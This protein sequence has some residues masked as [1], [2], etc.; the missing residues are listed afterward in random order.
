MKYH[1]LHE[2]GDFPILAVESVAS[3]WTNTI[4]KVVGYAENWAVFL[5]S[6]GWCRIYSKEKRYQQIVEYV[7]KKINQDRVYVNNVKKQLVKNAALFFEFANSIKK[8]DLSKFFFRDLIKLKEREIQLYH[9]TAIFGEPIPFFLKEKLQTELDQYLLVEKKVPLADYEKLITPV[10]Q[11]F[12]EREEIEL[13]KLSG[14]TNKKK[15][16]QALTRHAAKYNWIHFDYASLITTKKDFFNKLKQLKKQRPKLVSSKQRKSDKI[17][18]IKK[19]KINSQ[20]KYWLTVLDQAYFLMDYKKEKLTQVH[21][22]MT[23]VY[24]E[25]AKRVGLTLAEVRWL[26]WRELKSALHKNKKILKKFV[27]KRKRS[28]FVK[29]LNG[30]PSIVSAKQAISI[31]RD[32]N[33]DQRVDLNIKEISGLSGSPGKVRGR[34]CYLKSAK[35]CGKIKQGEILLV[36]NTTPDFMPA[37][38]KAKA[39]VTCEGGITCHAA[40][41]SRE[42]KIPCVVGTKIATQVLK[43][44]DR[45]EVNASKGIVRII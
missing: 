38:R 34:I 18:L 20:V 8:Y 30:H 28:C 41:V 31:I 14:I 2:R 25:M 27:H 12:I 9:K 15:L 29:Y 3:V 37:I 36:S 13:L 44:G 23:A 33:K 6:R 4:C 22:A 21:F 1:F 26:T 45:V 43:D 42:L 10:Y 40:I 39:I 19:Y 32:I 7:W 5:Y 16:D 35:E 17:K 11:S 24:Q